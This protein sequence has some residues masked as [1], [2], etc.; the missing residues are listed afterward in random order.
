VIPSRLEKES[1]PGAFSGTA[2]H[3][4]RLMGYEK[5]FVAL[6]SR[7]RGLKYVLTLGVRPNYLDYSPAERA[8][9]ESQPVILY[10]TRNYAQFFTTAGKRIFP[11]LETHLYADEKIKQTTLFQMLGIAHPRTKI[12][13]ALHHGDIVKDF[14]F[15][16]VAKIPR[17]SSRGRGVF[18][19]TNDDELS[20]YLR[21]V[22]VAYVQEYLPH[23]RD[24]RVVLINFEP[25]IAY[26]RVCMPGEFKANLAQGASIQFNDIPDEGVQFARETAERC[27]FNDVGMDLIESNKK[28]YAIEANMKYGR[29]AII[30]AGL[31]LTEIMGRKLLSGNLF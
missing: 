6:G 28:W 24:L 29:K 5:K 26:W 19:I 30:G 2:A 7:L 27:H 17:N 11:S 12:Y 21:L 3:G 15:P 1:I 22:K 4:L 23:E 18:L 13:Y 25:I 10:P 9:M 31:N 20:R 8:L 14:S 16:F